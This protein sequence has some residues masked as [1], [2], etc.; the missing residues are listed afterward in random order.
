MAE[1]L[2]SCGLDL[3]NVPVSAHPLVRMH[4]IPPRVVLAV[5]GNAQLTNTVMVPEVVL[6]NTADK[7]VWLFSRGVRHTSMTERMLSGWPDFHSGASPG[8]RYRPLKGGKLLIGERA[9]KRLQ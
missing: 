6:E 1:A 7:Q 4:R 9:K 3:A 5:A 2:G 8:F